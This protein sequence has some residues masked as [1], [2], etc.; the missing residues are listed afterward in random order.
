MRR[1]EHDMLIASTLHFHVDPAC[2]YITRRERAHRVM[3]THEFLAREIFQDAAFAAKRFGDQK[4]ARARVIKAGRM[5]LHELEIRDLCAGTK[6]HRD[7]IPGRG[8]G[9]GGVEI[10]LSGAAGGKNRDV[11]TRGHDFAC[12]LVQDIGA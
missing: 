12:L 4:V 3:L 5:K 8:V 1:I 10:N 2:D 6:C 11:R 7:A 9:I